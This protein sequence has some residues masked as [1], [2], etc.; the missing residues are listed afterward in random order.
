MILKVSKLTSKY[1]TWRTAESRTQYF[2][3]SST[4]IRYFFGDGEIIFLTSAINYYTRI[5]WEQIKDQDKAPMGLMLLTV[6]WSCITMRLE[7]LPAFNGI[8][9]IASG[10]LRRYSLWLGYKRQFSIFEKRHDFNTNKSVLCGFEI[11]IF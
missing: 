6:K 9:D 11:S 2:T 7:E 1:S 10:I 8:L 5:L 4:V 3:A